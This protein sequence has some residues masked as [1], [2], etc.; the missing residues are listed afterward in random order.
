M[1][2]SRTGSVHGINYKLALEAIS[3]HA[4]TDGTTDE[5]TL[6]EPLEKAFQAFV[7][8]NGLVTELIGSE[9][10]PTVP[11]RSAHAE[12]KLFLPEVTV[13][14]SVD[15]E[16]HVPNSGGASFDEQV[17]MGL[18]ASMGPIVDVFKPQSPPEYNLLAK[19]VI[20]L[21]MC[22]R[23]GGGTPYSWITV[24][25]ARRRDPPR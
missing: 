23:S 7:T 12:Q 17:D 10:D 22:S 4:A 19:A 15:A 1:K 8:L 24:E 14:A 9:H 18:R 5:T 25:E 13:T 20:E 11:V 3:P 2:R 21:S 16:G 6:I